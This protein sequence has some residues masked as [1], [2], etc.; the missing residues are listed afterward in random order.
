MKVSIIGQGYVGQ[1]LA[2]GAAKSGYEVIGLDLNT[3]IISD[4]E[5]GKSFVPGIKKDILCELIAKK[6]YVPTTDFELMHGS[7]IIIIAVPTQ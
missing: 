7:K 4:L 2:I 1:T 3:K 6:V 5:R